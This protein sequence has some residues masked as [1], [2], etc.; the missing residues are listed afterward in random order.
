ML[1]LLKLKIINNACD[2]CNILHSY[3]I[4][5]LGLIVY[6]PN[7]G[8]GGVCNNTYNIPCTVAYIIIIIILYALDRD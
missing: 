8:T 5:L 2:T 6:L 4:Q 1:H 7:I 3:C